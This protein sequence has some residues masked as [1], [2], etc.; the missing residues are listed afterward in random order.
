MTVNVVILLVEIGNFGI[1][2]R[3]IVSDICLV[4]LVASYFLIVSLLA[5]QSQ[6]NAVG[7][8]YIVI[9]GSLPQQP[10]MSCSAFSCAKRH[11]KESAS[12]KYIYFFQIWSFLAPKNKMATAK[13]QTGGFKTQTNV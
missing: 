5:S 13:L 10:V 4:F 7:R 3:I 9:D 8:G 12:S 2:I 6:W 1:K 11:S